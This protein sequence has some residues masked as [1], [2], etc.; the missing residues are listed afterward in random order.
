MKYIK[1]MLIRIKTILSSR[2]GFSLLEL[3]IVVVIL[4]ILI[5]I[6]GPKFMGQTDKAKVSSAKTQIGNFATALETYKL[7][8]GNYPTTEQGL[9]ALVEKPG[10]DPIPQSYASKGYLNSKSVPVDPWK[11][12][13]VYTSDGNE[14]LIVTLGADGKEGGT[15]FNADIKS[16]DLGK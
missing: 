10:S 15:E 3:M 16:D 6:V 14:F 8:N 7:D 11:R 13:Y 12:A 4:A 5:G 2:D 9:L 1:A